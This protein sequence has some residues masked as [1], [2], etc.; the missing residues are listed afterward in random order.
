MLQGHTRITSTKYP[1]FCMTTF[2]ASLTN[3]T[4]LL[5]QSRDCSSYV[6]RP[7]LAPPPLGLQE[8]TDLCAQDFAHS[9]DLWS[10][11]RLVKFNCAWTWRLLGITPAIK[12]ASVTRN[13]TLLTC[14][15]SL[16]PIQLG[17][18]GPINWN[19]CGLVTAIGQTRDLEFSAVSGTR[20]SE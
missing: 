15:S 8:H 10:Q 12:C 1:S 4:V 18:S 19:V 16:L 6:S 9:T 7:I 3:L 14:G 5:P 17:H 2:S 11:P 13:V 20:S